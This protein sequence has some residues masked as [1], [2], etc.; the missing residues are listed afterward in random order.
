MRSNILVIA[1]QALLAAHAAGSRNVHRHRL[2]RQQQQAGTPAPPLLPPRFGVSPEDAA[3][4]GP[5]AG[6]WIDITDYNISTDGTRDVSGVVTAIGRANTHGAVLLFPGRLGNG[7]DGAAAGWLPSKY[8]IDPAELLGGYRAWNAPPQLTLW[9]EPGAAL[10]TAAGVRVYLGGPVRA[11]GYHIFDSL[12][13]PLAA[14][15][16]K[17]LL[18]VGP[19]VGP[20]SAFCSCILTGM[21]GPTR[22]FWANLTPFSLQITSNGTNATVTVGA[23][24]GLKVGDRFRV[25]GAAQPEFNGYWSVFT[26]SGASFSYQMAEQP[27]PSSTM[28]EAGGA[29]QVTFAGFYFGAQKQRHNLPGDADS[30][31]AWAYP[32][33]WGASPTNTGVDDTTAVQ[34]ALDCGFPVRFLQSYNVERVTMTGGTVLDGSNHQLVGNAKRQTNAVLEVKADM[35]DIHNLQVIRRPGCRRA[36]TCEH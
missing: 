19:E 22:I 15:V 3:S 21:H 27:D 28:A 30:P 20:N 13:H 31:N 24:Q 33:W 32:E 5:P 16:R 6:D 34:F 10:V 26:A 17:T 14:Q 35:S 18:L 11:G 1:F 29:P 23:G 9:L 4:P 8:L 2:R 25:A 7:P 36:Q 12:S